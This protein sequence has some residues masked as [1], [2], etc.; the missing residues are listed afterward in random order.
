[1][2]FSR[3]LIDRQAYTTVIKLTSKTTYFYGSAS[4]FSEKKN[5]V[6]VVAADKA[7]LAPHL[8]ANIIANDRISVPAH[9]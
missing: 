1:M 4:A 9:L 6:F 3:L 2:P 5:V 8:V 7:E